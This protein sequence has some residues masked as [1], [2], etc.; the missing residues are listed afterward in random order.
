MQSDVPPASSNNTTTT[1]TT[2]HPAT[3]TI[4]KNK[5]RYNRPKF[6]INVSHADSE[7]IE[8]IYRAVDL[9]NNRVA[10][11]GAERQKKLKE[12]MTYFQQAHMLRKEA[13][14]MMSELQQELLT[15]I[16][17][18]PAT[19][20]T[21]IRKPATDTLINLAE[22]CTKQSTLLPPTRTQIPPFP[23]PSTPTQPPQHSSQRPHSPQPPQQQRPHSPPTSNP[24]SK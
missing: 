10:Y 2:H 22:E 14:K 3:K 7:R 6:L 21:S 11:N 20:S 13:E 9:V 12:M 1:T 8:T 18:P 15:N 19:A 5:K 24:I 23:V 16:V 17:F 4:D